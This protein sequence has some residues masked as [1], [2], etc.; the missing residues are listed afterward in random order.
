[1]QLKIPFQSP[2]VDRYLEAAKGTYAV[3]VGNQFHW[4]LKAGYDKKTDYVT[5]KLERDLS[6]KL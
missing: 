3:E 4:V 2:E 6:A 1:M 5:F